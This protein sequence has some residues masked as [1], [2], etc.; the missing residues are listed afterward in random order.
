MPFAVQVNGMRLNERNDALSRV[1]LARSW[2]PDDDNLV[3]LFP[4]IQ[5]G[6][7]NEPFNPFCQGDHLWVM[8][9]VELD[10]FLPPFRTLFE[11]KL[12]DHFGRHQ[13]RGLGILCSIH[14]IQQFLRYGDSHSFHGSSNLLVH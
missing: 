9:F 4:F 14:R 7:A 1:A 12:E 8:S 2:A 13:W 6:P 10:D 5:S 3:P 11:V